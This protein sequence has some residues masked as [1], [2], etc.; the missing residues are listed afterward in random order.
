V[1]AAVE[2]ARELGMI[3]DKAYA[4]AYTR[5]QERG[6]LK[7][8][9]AIRHELHQRGVDRDTAAEAV[10]A[11]EDPE[12]QRANAR[13]AAERKAASLAREAP[14]KAR[15]KLM[16]YLLRKGYD[17]TVAAEVTRELLGGNADE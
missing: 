12:A 8:P 7:G 2:H 17:G 6:A 13:R 16:Q 15:L 10:A 1:A 14:A 3:D 4:G 5:T 11:A 9:R